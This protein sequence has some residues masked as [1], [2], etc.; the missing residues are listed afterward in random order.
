MHAVCECEYA[1][2]GACVCEC[3]RASVLS[4]SRPLPRACMVHAHCVFASQCSFVCVRVCLCVHEREREMRVAVSDCACV[5]AYIRVCVCYS[6]CLVRFC[7][8][9]RERHPAAKLTGGNGAS[10]SRQIG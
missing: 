4:M 5:R 1:V 9:I 7:R 8:D 10:A 6:L 3:A 2:Y